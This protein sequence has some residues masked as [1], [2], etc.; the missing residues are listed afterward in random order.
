MG[1]PVALRG[2][3]RRI[4]LEVI[5]QLVLG[6][7]DPR[8][9]AALRS[10]LAPGVGPML[11]VMSYA[12]TLWRRDG[13]LN[14]GRRLKRRR[15]LIHRMLLEQIAIRRANGRRGERDDALSLLIDGG[16]EA[17]RPPSDLELRDQLIGLLLAGHDTTAA[18]LTWTIE[19]IS[20]A[21]GV[22]AQL[23]RAVAAGDDAYVDAVVREAL[24]TR[25]PVVDVPRRTAWEIE[26][27]G[28][29][30]PP[31]T[32]VNAMLALTHRRADLWAEP[33]AFRP[34]RFLEG[35]PIPY[36]YAPFGGGLRGCV[37]AALGTLQLHVVLTE[38]L[39]R[40]TVRAAPGPEER[41]HLVGP[42]L[43]PWRGGRVVLGARG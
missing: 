35:Q 12:P 3:M 8:R 28:H 1:R 18:A 17:E 9:R 2:P 14:P 31:G 42:T 21:P 37:A 16:E 20:R 4:A 39:R 32:M 5:G 15:D 23:S 43:V 7:D 33:R 36:A 26:L 38:L 24:R 30:V 27:A 13:P 29:R 10:A 41:A 22:E 34:E 40:F 11:A 25:P 19:R 6:I